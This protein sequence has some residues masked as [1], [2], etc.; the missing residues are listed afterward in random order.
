MAGGRLVA[1]RKQRRMRV[2]HRIMSGA[3]DWIIFPAALTFMA[4][5][6]FGLWRDYGPKGRNMEKL[7]MC[8][9]A[10]I[11]EGSRERLIACELEAIA[12]TR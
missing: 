10:A 2:H 1:G 3:Y 4:V 9:R 8:E 6:A 7:L 5:I 12:Y 11:S